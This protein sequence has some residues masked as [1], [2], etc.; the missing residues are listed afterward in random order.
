M[1]PSIQAAKYAILAVAAVF[2]WQSANVNFNYGGSWSALFLTGSAFA[3]PAELA[4]EGIYQFPDSDG[5]D[6]QFYHYI[7]HDPP[8]NKG[9]AAA[10]DDPGLRWRRILVPGLAALLSLGQPDWVDASYLLVVYAFIGMGVYWLSLMA[11]QYHGH[12]AWGL[13]FV[14]APATAISIERMTVDV[15]VTALTVG[16]AYYALNSRSAATWSMLALAP[17]ARETGVILIAVHAVYV[18]TAGRRRELLAAI[19]CGLP[20]FAWDLYLLSMTSPPAASGWLGLPL[21]GLVDRTLGGFPPNVQ[22]SKVVVALLLDFAGVAGA[23]IALVQSARFLWP[24]LTRGLRALPQTMGPVEWGVAF[25]CLAAVVL[26]SP[27][28]W[29]ST[30][31]F[32]RVLS[33]WLVFLLLVAIRDRRYWFALPCVLM[34]LHVAAQAA[35]HLVGMFRNVLSA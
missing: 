11:I 1:K 5:Y 27:K 25:F 29:F 17:L 24:R 15:A 35:V 18:F 31:S 28:V 30:Y 21:S 6:G 34:G 9:L 16:Y 2:L 13:A 3:V 14:A 26:G 19:L 10:V 32:A 33:P 12:A 20:F 23:W 4:A 8:M 22:S 7:A